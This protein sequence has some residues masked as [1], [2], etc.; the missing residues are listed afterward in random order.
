MSIDNF[1]IYSF[2]Q[3]TSSVSLTFST[4]NLSVSLNVILSK[5]THERAPLENSLLVI[6]LFILSAICAALALAIIA[7]TARDMLGS[8]IE[9]LLL[10]AFAGCVCMQ[11]LTQTVLYSRGSPIIGALTTAL[12]SCSM[13]LGVLLFRPHDTGGALAVSTLSLLVGII[14]ACPWIFRHGVLSDHAI[15]WA[16]AVSF[17]RRRG[18]EL[19]HFSLLALSGGFVFQIALWFMQLRLVQVAGAG[20]NA[21]FALG[22][23]FYNVIIFLPTI[24]GPVLLRRMSRQE[25][26]AI[27]RSET[28]LALVLVTAL[29]ALGVFVFG[30]LEHFI[31]KVLPNRYAGAFET[32]S[33]GVIAGALM[34]AKFPLSVYFQS[35]LSGVPEAAAN[36]ISALLVAGGALL[37]YWS[38]SALHSMEL[39]SLGHAVQFIAI[40]VAFMIIG[41]WVKPK[42]PPEQ[43]GCSEVDPESMPRLQQ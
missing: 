36:F 32:I 41:P 15:I 26:D 7:C 24:F 27:K 38:G 37:P 13:C 28:L 29:C 33:W 21:P 40:G 4:L 17:V 34:F 39:R 3:S 43:P 12:V 35:R 14:L 19:L 8:I 11:N 42:Q 31:L 18:I 16:S 23:Q 30:L 5:G 20:A 22:V 6:L 1:G 9:W 2:L 25:N 10:A